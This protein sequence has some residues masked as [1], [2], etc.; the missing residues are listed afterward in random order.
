MAGQNLKAKISGGRKQ[1]LARRISTVHDRF[2]GNAGALQ[3]EGSF[4][5]RIVRRV[6]ANLGADSNAVVIE[7]GTGRRC[8]HDAGTIVVGE[9]H[10][11]FDRTCGN[12]HLLRPYLPQPFARQVRIGIGQVVGHPLDQRHEILSVVAESRG[13]AEQSHIIH[14]R[15]RRSRIRGPLEARLAVDHYA[16]FMGKRTAELRLLIAQD[17]VRTA[18]GGC[19]CSGQT[20]S[21]AAEHQHI[22]INIAVGIVV[23]IALIRRHAQSGRASD[24]R[25]IETLPG[26]LRPHEGLVVEAGREQWRQKIVDSTDIKGKRRPAVLRHCFHAVEHFL[27]SCPDIGLLARPCRVRCPSVRSALPLPRQPLRVDGDT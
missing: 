5:G 23:R 14:G 24:H 18:F 17:H 13:A 8:Q 26:G 20:G 1:P 7:I 3:I 2:N 6:D 11:P 21:A 15:K 25:F 10:R 16:A 22:R 9:Y 12:D 27:N 4:V 19:K